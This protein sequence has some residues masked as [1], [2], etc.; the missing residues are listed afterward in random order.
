MSCL[1][2]K[3]TNDRPKYHVAKIWYNANNSVYDTKI[4]IINIHLIKFNKI[5]INYL[6]RFVQSIK[7]NMLVCLIDKIVQQILYTYPNST[8][9]TTSW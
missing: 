5:I 8:E 7:K 2:K 1:S 9:A 3:Y 6:V 4:Y